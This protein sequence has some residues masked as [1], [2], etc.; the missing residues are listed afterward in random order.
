MRGGINVSITAESYVYF[1]ALLRTGD[2]KPFR[3]L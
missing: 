1:D 3:G 2:G